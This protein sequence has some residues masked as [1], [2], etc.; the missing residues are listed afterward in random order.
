MSSD[1]LPAFS[2]KQYKI[3][4][5]STTYNIFV[6]S[7]TQVIPDEG[8]CLFYWLRKENKRAS[9]KD[10]DLLD[11]SSKKCVLFSCHRSS[12]GILFL[13]YT[14][15]LQNSITKFISPWACKARTFQIS[16]SV[17]HGQ[18][19]NINIKMFV[20]DSWFKLQRQKQEVKEQ[21]TANHCYE[22][23]T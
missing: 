2:G 5:T 12:H 19:S 14:T 8:I 7:P 16:C 17:G 15:V 23:R 6:P 1:V 9:G 13:T 20:F 18:M 11:Q 10:C 21:I 4:G 22:K 3:S